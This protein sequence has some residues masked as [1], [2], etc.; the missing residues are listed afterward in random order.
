MNR[1]ERGLNGF[2][3]ASREIMSRWASKASTSVMDQGTYS[4]ANFLLNILLARDLGLKGYGAF[5]TVY[6]AYLFFSVFSNALIY[7]PMNIISMLDYSERRQVYARGILILQLALSLIFSTGLAITGWLM[8]NLGNNLALSL[9]AMSISLPFMSLF[10]LMRRMA[11]LDTRPLVSFQGSAGY[12]VL[13]GIG[14]ALLLKSG[15]LSAE[16]AILLMGVGSAAMVFVMWVKHKGDGSLPRVSVSLRDVYGVIRKHWDLGRWLLASSVL[17]WLALYAYVPL[18]GFLGRLASAASLKAIENLTL[19]M[20]QTLSI[21]GTLFIPV[22]A[23]KFTANH[24]SLAKNT[25]QVSMVVGL[26]TLGYVVVLSMGS[27][28]ILGEVYGHANEYV[29]YYYLVPIISINLLLRVVSD[30]H[31]GIP[32][33]VHQRYDLLFKATVISTTVL[34]FAGV[35]LVW[36]FNLIGA[37]IAKVLPLAAQCLFLFFLVRKTLGGAVV[38]S[39]QLGT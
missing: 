14:Y 1:N 2:L 21:L 34:L 6:A 13:L 20:D 28:V 4:G 17:A 29:E 11:Y 7:D 19:P 33:R 18:L 3:G 31:L 27:R 15:K 5:A 38:T 30:F 23:Q 10:L 24:D 9:V 32:L 22:I 8:L 35:A 36:R 37:A 25:R 26:I 16:S 12:L 39:R